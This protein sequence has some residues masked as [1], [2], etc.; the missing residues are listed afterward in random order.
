M[1]AGEGGQ[2]LPLSHQGRQV[3]HL[4]IRGRRSVNIPS[5]LSAQEICLS[6]QQAYNKVCQQVP[7]E[8]SPE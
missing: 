7:W 3:H 8:H 5:V 2:P 6:S 1:F 4:G